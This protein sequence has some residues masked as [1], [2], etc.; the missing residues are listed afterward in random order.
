MLLKYPSLI[1]EPRCTYFYSNENVPASLY[2]FTNINSRLPN[3]QN[4]QTL[5]SFHKGYINIVIHTNSVRQS[6]LAFVDSG[7]T[8][9]YHCCLKGQFTKSLNVKIDKRADFICS[10]SDAY[11]MRYEGVTSFKM[12]LQIDSKTIYF[13]MNCLVLTDLTDNINIGAHFLREFEVSLI[14]SKK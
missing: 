10:A 4:I 9:A 6:A 14:F 11:N 7:S 3:F 12:S 13:D 2:Q 1:N 5:G 8:I